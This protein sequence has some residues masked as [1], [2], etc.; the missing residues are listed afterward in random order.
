MPLGKLVHVK[1][2]SSLYPYSEVKSKL[3]S[4]FAVP[5]VE[6]DVGDAVN[7]KSPTFN[8]GVD[9]KVTNPSVALTENGY[10]PGGS[11]VVV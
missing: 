10:C 1:V 7:A 9:V 2:A 8:V 3:N 11:E 4:R 6:T 5:G